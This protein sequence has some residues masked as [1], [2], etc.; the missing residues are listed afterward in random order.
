MQVQDYQFVASPQVARKTWY[1]NQISKGKSFYTRIIEIPSHKNTYIA[2]ILGIYCDIMIIISLRKC[3][4]IICIVGD[5]SLCITVFMARV[6]NCLMSCKRVLIT[7]LY[8][9]TYLPRRGI[10]K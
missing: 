8:C 2:V 5:N 1:S 9:C 6:I 10:T 4:N 7:V 3:K